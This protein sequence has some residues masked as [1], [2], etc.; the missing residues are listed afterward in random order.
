M[1]A[2]TCIANKELRYELLQMMGLKGIKRTAELLG[3]SRQT[4]ERAAGGLTIQS[5]SELLLMKKM[6]ERGK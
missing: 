2:N 1:P 6:A 5:G 3:M 4:I